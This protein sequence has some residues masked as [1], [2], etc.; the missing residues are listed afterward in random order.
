MVNLTDLISL[1]GEMAQVQKE[2]EGL[3]AKE[4]QLQKMLDTLRLTDI[5]AA[6]DETGIGKIAL[7]KVGTLYLSPDVR[8]AVR[9][10]T[11]IKAYRWLED[12]GYGDLIQP[13]V[14]PQT[15]KVW[16]RER[17]KAGDELP[18]FFTVEPYQMAK[19][20]KG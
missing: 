20:L 3:K 10:G 18:D 17:I 12:N 13:H 16:A 8:A 2:L 15:L 6:M 1:A 9:G 14:F 19:I 11:K 7:A 5:P 4:K